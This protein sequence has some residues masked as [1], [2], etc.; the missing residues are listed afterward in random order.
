MSG[1]EVAGVAL[2]VFPILVDGLV[3]YV[4][5][6]Q[7]IKVWRRYRAKLQDYADIMNTHWV[8]YQDTLEEL[9]EGIVRSEDDISDLIAQP[10]GAI[11]KNP[12]YKEKLRER[13]GRSHAVYLRTSEKLV[14]GLREMCEK[15]EIDLSGKVSTKSCSLRPRRR[16]LKPNFS[17]RFFRMIP[18]EWSV[19]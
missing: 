5:G 12:E 8:Y 19:R 3:R 10:R 1:F 9:L 18:R 15:L 4:D 6:V 13:L 16:K 14:D 2:A 17:N 7:T 11:W